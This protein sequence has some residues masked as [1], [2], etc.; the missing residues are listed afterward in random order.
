MA[1]LNSAGMHVPLWMDA[2]PAAIGW[3]QNASYPVQE[4]AYFGNVMRANSDG[5]LHA[6]YCEGRDYTKGIVPGRLGADSTSNI[7]QNPWGAGAYCDDHC[8]KYGTDGYTSC[9][10]VSNPITVWRQASYNPVFDNNY[11][12]ELVNVN[13]Q[14]ALDVTGSRTA[15]NTLIDQYT[16]RGSANQQ[17][18]IIQVASSQ[19]KIIDT[20]SG[21]ALTNRE[22]GSGYVTLN[23]YSGADTDNWSIDDHNGHFIIKN[24]AS[25]A[26]LQVPSAAM[27]ANLVVTTKYCGAPDTDWDLLAVNSL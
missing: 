8:T 25:G 12:Y 4:G 26:Y 16:Y 13:S 3:G 15:E 22:G 9:N 18:Q 17:F 7:Y 23:S 21:K 2:A 27:S 19:W 14:L 1:R 11:I 20:H 10:G 6:W 24:K 5:T